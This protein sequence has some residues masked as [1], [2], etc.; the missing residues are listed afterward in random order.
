MDDGGDATLLIHKEFELEEFYENNYVPDIKTTIEEEIVIEKLIREVLK[1]DS[2]HWRSVAKNIIGVSEETT[3]GAYRLVQM[4]K[5]GHLLFPA[6]NVN[7]SVTKAKFDNVYGCRES[8]VDGPKRSLDIMVAGKTVLVCG[9]GD[10]G[11]GS[12]NL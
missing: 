7:D 2:S 9:Y 11:K 1:K 8:L 4:D 12:L 6:Y 5:D 3:T 10:V